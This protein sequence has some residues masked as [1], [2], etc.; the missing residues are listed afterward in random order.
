MQQRRRR[1]HDGVM[2]TAGD[3]KLRTS[4]EWLLA[5]GAQLR[6]RIERVRDDL[7]R[8]TNPL[9]RNT[10]DAAIVIENDEV[11][12]ALEETAR[13]E[14]HQIEHALEQI[15]VGTFAHCEACGAEIESER[16]EVVP[17]ATRCRQC[18]RD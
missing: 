9:P 4:R 15:A 5:R 13:R 16:L 1:C 17:Y 10:R 11:L 12:Q 7:R 2:N 18:A 6:D 14:L 3:E 8:A